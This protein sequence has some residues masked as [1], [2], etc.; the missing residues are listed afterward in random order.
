MKPSPFPPAAHMRSK[1]RSLLIESLQTAPIV[2]LGLLLLAGM[3]AFFLW[4]PVTYKDWVVSFQPAALQ[5]LSPYH[6]LLSNPPWL[7]PLLYP[8]ALLPSRLGAALLMTISLALIAAYLRSPWKTF[9]VAISAPMVAVYTLGQ[10]DALPLLGWL[11]PGG[12]GLPF[13]LLKPQGLFLTILPRLS[14]RALL[15]T[16]VLLFASVLIWGF[17]WQQTTGAA[18]FLSAAHNVSFFPYGVIPGLVLLYLGW[19]KKSDALLCVAS[20]CISPYFMTTSLLPAVAA[21]LRETEDKRWWLLILFGSWIFYFAAR[22]L[23]GAF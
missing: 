2:I 14:R 22:K 1:A 10:I 8:L 4:L 13:L 21:G 23:T 20:L 19:R 9:I 15:I 3:A 17:W 12:W 6:G 18:Y 7:F 5:P 11:I 16:G